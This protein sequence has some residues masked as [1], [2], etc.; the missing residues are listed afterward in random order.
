M[1]FKFV[2]IDPSLTGTGICTEQQQTLLVSSKLSGAARL[3]DLRE[4]ISRILGRLC[5]GS[6]PTN[7]VILE[8][9]S[10]AS[11]NGAHQLGEWGGVLRLL[12]YELG[13]PL[14]L[15]SPNGLKL[16]ATGKHSASKEVVMSEITHRAGR[17]FAT[18]DEAE[19]WCLGAM[20]ADFYGFAWVK[21]P[22]KNREAL[23]AIDWPEVRE[24]DRVW[25][26]SPPK[27]KA[28]KSR[29]KAAQ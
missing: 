21:M 4:M 1:S 27:A 8:N 29:K 25:P 10:Y 5:V 15:V 18:Q 2:A 24:G 19:A 26:G 16:Y 7:L 23:E 14:A 13:I 6:P 22:A 17:T 12:I 11:S 20:A 3:L 28:K 9:H